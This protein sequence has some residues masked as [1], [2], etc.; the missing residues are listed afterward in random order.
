MNIRIFYTFLGENKILLGC[1]ADVTAVDKSNNELTL[2]SPLM[3]K[4]IWKND[5][6]NCKV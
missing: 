6:T 4:K 3:E 5:T 1:Q 2:L